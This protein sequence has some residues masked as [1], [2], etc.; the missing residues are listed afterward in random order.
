MSQMQE[1]CRQMRVP[2][3]VTTSLHERGWITQQGRGGAI[4][5]HKNGFD[6]C[7]LLRWIEKGDAHCFVTSGTDDISDFPWVQEASMPAVFESTLSDRHLHD[8]SAVEEVLSAL[9][10]FQ[11]VVNT[12]EEDH[13]CT[14]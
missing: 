11:A 3:A 12:T 9:K 7:I 1:W 4:F 2:A 6:I 5:K 8:E 10:A 13:A 14:K